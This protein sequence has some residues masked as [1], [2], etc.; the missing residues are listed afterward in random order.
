MSH[1][2]KAGAEP[3]DRLSDRELL[4][5][6]REAP[7]EAA[8][9]AAAGELLKRYR[10]P[11]YVW[12]F[13]YVGEHERALDMAQDVLLAVY[14]RMGEF[15]GRAAF[16]SWLYAI[17]RNRCLNE[18]RRDDMWA[19]VDPDSLIDESNRFDERLDAEIQSEKLVALAARVLDEQERKAIW[20]RYAELMSV[21]QITAVLKLDHKSGARAV[22]QRARR[23]LRDE[24]KT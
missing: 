18:I 4:D 19:D 8:A 6:A 21:D 16:S 7:G 22:L 20:L 14:Q 17:T 13:R 23:K 2:M 1:P 3:V 11:V 10:R 15:E 5:R 24:W 9:R 12:C